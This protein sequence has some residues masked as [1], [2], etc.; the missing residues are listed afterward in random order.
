MP[1][2]HGILVGRQEQDGE[3]FQKLWWL[4]RAGFTGDLMVR[5]ERLDAPGRMRV[6]AVNWGHS[7]DGRGSWAS[8]VTFSGEG[9]WRIT[10]RVRDVTLS[11][12]VKVVP[13]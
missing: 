1:G 6:L 5:G 8:A 7:S 9:C 4:P 10:G 3:L 11:Y 2:E 13:G 12:V